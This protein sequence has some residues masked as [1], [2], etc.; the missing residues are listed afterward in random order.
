MST[1]PVCPGG[2]GKK[3]EVFPAV[4]FGHQLGLPDAL[5]GAAVGPQQ[6][7]LALRQQPL[8]QPAHVP[9]GDVDEALR[10]V[11]EG[12]KRGGGGAPAPGR[13]RP[14]RGR[15]R[16][17]RRCGSGNASRPAA[18]ASARLVVIQCST[19]KVRPCQKPS[20][21]ARASTSWG[22]KQTSSGRL[23]PAN[24]R[25]AG[26]TAPPRCAPCRGRPRSPRSCPGRARSFFSCIELL[27]S[28]C[29]SCSNYSHERLC[30]QG[31]LSALFCAE[32]WG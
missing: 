8:H 28:C 14:F 20:S 22:R 18:S 12:A 32:K 24:H 11:E 30:R 21:L 19:L 6:G 7:H 27:L 5:P 17:P 1:R 10:D 3:P 13:P 16:S 26:R 15:R 25:S 23:P 9:D 31:K 29:F 4:T 2:S